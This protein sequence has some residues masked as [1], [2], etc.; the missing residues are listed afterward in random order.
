MERR[1]F[2]IADISCG[3]WLVEVYPGVVSV[4]MTIPPTL[5]APSLTSFF[6]VVEREIT[7]HEPPD[8]DLSGCHRVR[9]STGIEPYVQE[10]WFVRIRIERCLG[11]ERIRCEV[12]L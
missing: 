11:D 4:W 10:A 6:D 2:E 12:S 3:R 1:K 8:I 9:I 5:P 7:G